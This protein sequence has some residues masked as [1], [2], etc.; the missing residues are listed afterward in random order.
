MSSELLQKN[1]LCCLLRRYVILL[2]ILLL[3]ILFFQSFVIILQHYSLNEEMCRLYHVSH[4]SF[5]KRQDT[6]HFSFFWNRFCKNNAYDIA[7]W[8]GF[9]SAHVYDGMEDLF[10]SGLIVDCQH[11]STSHSGSGSGSVYSW[12]TRSRQYTDLRSLQPK[13]VPPLSGQR[14]KLGTY[15]DVV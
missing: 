14:H 4:K 2:W 5:Q 9:P 11:R 15:V 12:V 1:Y 7:F 3:F 8:Q 6:Q 13:L 10:N